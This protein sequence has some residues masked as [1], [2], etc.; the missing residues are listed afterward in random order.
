MFFDESGRETCEWATAKFPENLR[1][2]H[3]EEW[4]VP[5]AASF[6]DSSLFELLTLEIFQAGLSWQIVLNK[7]D[8]FRE[9]FLGFDIAKVAKMNEFDVE[10]LLQNPAIIRNKMKIEATINNARIFCEKF[11]TDGDFAKYLWS[12]TNGKIINND[13]AKF[14]DTP[15][16]TDLSEE[17]S[18]NMK[19]LGFKFTGPT[20]IYSYL[21]GVGIVND[22]AKNCW[23]SSEIFAK[24]NDEIR[25]IGL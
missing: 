12:F 16:K 22:H 1:A 18:R 5:T 10:K 13:F 23:R 2:Y 11:P 19:K 9:S 15:A 17:I 7:R 6:D 24:F 20:A 3:D 21:Q 14:A 8:A 4:G 25:E